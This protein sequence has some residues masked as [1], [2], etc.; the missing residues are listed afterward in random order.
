MLGVTSRSAVRKSETGEAGVRGEGVR[1]H[2]L[3]AAIA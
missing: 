2:V 3:E 1:S